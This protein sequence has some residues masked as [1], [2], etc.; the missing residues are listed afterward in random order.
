MIPSPAL[1]NV[2]AHES[3]AQESAEYFR[4]TP[5][6]IPELFV[7]LSHPIAALVSLDCKLQPRDAPEPCLET[8]RPRNPLSGLS[9]GSSRPHFIYVPSLKT[10]SYKKGYKNILY[11]T[12]DI[13]NIL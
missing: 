12:G 3:A 9:S 4:A 2:C 11:N 8:L 10:I 1:S 13:S 6:R 5:Y 7:G